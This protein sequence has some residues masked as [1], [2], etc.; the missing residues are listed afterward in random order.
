MLDLIIDALV[1]NLLTT[2]EVEDVAA[3][4]YDLNSPE[5]AVEADRW[6]GELSTQLVV[7]DL[8]HTSTTT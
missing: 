6:A 4:I 5:A 8:P 2:I 1:D 7:N 3:K